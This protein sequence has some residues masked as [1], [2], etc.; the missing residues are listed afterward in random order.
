MHYTIPR[1]HSKDVRLRHTS[2]KFYEHTVANQG[3]GNKKEVV[4][5]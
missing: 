5:P 4:Y 2:S 3:D 1:D